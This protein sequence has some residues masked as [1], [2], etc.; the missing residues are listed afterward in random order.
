MFVSLKHRAWFPKIGVGY[1]G[2]GKSL[3][4]PLPGY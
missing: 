1:Q 4:L 2:G 3:V